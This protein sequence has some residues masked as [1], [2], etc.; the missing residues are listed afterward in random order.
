VSS[1]VLRLAWRSKHCFVRASPADF[2]AEVFRRFERCAWVLTRS[3][4]T[5]HRKSRP[6]FAGS[7][8]L[9][10]VSLLV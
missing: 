1:L 5:L 7:T 9:S 3:S 2:P 4:T 10:E 8:R 6:S